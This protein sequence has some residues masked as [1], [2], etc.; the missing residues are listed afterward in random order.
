MGLAFESDELLI[1]EYLKVVSMATDLRNESQSDLAQ[2]IMKKP[3]I[4]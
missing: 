3:H 4:F 2:A 1:T